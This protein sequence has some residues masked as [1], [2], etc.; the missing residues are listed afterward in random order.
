VRQERGRHEAEREVL[1]LQT[2]DVWLR[3][4]GTGQWEQKRKRRSRDYE[5]EKPEKQREGRGG[6]RNRK[7]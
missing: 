6:E 7:V 3:R 5:E 2:S 1:V 4:R